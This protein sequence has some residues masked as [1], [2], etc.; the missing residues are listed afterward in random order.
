LRHAARVDA[1]QAE[2]VSAMRQAGAS[3]WIIKLPVDLL[4]GINNRTA[5][6]EVKTLTGKRAPKAASYTPLQ[7][8]FMDAWKGGTVATITDVRSALEL[9]AVMRSA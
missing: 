7:E 1:N 5:L 6:V 8:A 3:V 9:L 2:I 4:V